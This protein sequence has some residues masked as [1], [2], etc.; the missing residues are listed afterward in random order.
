LVDSRATS[1]L[2]TC[3]FTQRSEST[4]SRKIASP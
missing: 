1:Q 4:N 2:S 3:G